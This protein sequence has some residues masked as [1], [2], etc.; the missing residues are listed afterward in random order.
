[1]ST[2]AS[3]PRLPTSTPASAS[4]APLVLVDGACRTDLAVLSVRMTGPLDERSARLTL[5]RLAA[6][7]DPAERSGVDRLLGRSVTLLQPA[8][9][10]GGSNRLI[11]LLA[12]RIESAEMSLG[13]QRDQWVLL[14]SCDWSRTAADARPDQPITA[15]EMLDRLGVWRRLISAADEQELRARS[16]RRASQLATLLTELGMQVHRRLRW[17]GGAVRERRSLR[18]RQGG[19][20]IRLGMTEGAPGAG[21]VREWSARTEAR[22]PIRFIAAAPGQ[23]VESTFDLVGGWDPS[24]EGL[25]ESQYAR[26]TSD[27][28]AAVANVHRLWVLNEDGAFSGAPFMRALFDLTAFFDE[29]QAVAARALPLGDA[30]TLDEAGRSV[31]VLVEWSMDGGVS[32]SVYPG[33]WRR[34]PDRAGIHLD[35]DALPAGWIAAVE[36]GTGRVRATGTLTSP[37][38]MRSV[39]WRGNPFEGPFVTRHF[40]LS[41][42]FAWRRLDSRSRFSVEVATGLRRADT[43]DQRPAMR[44]WLE[45]RARR[46]GHDGGQAEMTV[47][48]PAISLRLGDRLAVLSGRRIGLET[49]D[50]A[51]GEPRAELESMEHDWEHHRSRLTWKLT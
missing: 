47:R 15:A 32:W 42:R 45:D 44:A 49:G 21:V 5:R 27:D 22:R 16:V 39:R 13:A 2:A 37:N 12:G 24:L 36:G 19:R 30:L 20:P 7:H 38:A 4:E 29:G 31:G 35:D 1:M 33:L 48:G 43:I 10:H 46:G 50:P 3:I 14:A 25:A 9:I 41:G 17:S 11:P 34:L 18:P 40:D 51:S 23:R 6:A 8:A 26:S 28:F